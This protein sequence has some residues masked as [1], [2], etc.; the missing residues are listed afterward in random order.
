ME[1]KMA[2]FIFSL[3]N[4]LIFR[5][6]AKTLAPHLSMWI[7]TSSS[8]LF[9][10]WVDGC[11]HE[12]H[13]F[14]RRRGAVPLGELS[15]ESTQLARVRIWKGSPLTKV[16]RMLKIP[17]LK[18]RSFSDSDKRSSISFSSFLAVSIKLY[19]ASLVVLVADL[20]WNDQSRHACS[21][22][23]LSTLL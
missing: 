4:S 17:E 16:P 18:D 15:L 11:H 1:I 12:L 3:S 14:H 7:A 22:V 8:P 23:K 20:N 21:P 6:S 5:D 2:A 19:A 13:A 10:F 9:C